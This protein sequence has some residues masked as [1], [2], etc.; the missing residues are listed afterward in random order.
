MSEEN[1]SSHQQGLVVVNTSADLQQMQPPK[2][3]YQLATSVTH[4]MRPSVETGRVHVV[5]SEEED[6]D[7]Y[8]D[9]DDEEDDGLVIDLNEDDEDNNDE[10]CTQTLKNNNNNNI[11]NDSEDRNECKRIKLCDLEAQSSSSSS[12]SS[13]GAREGV[14]SN[15]DNDA[16]N[17]NSSDGDDESMLDEVAD[18]DVDT[19]DENDYFVMLQSKVVPSND[20]AERR[21]DHDYQSDNLHNKILRLPSSSSS[22]ALLNPPICVQQLDS[23]HQFSYSKSGAEAAEAA[24]C[25]NLDSR[26]RRGNLPKDSV[27]VLK[28]WLY[29][30]RYNAYPTENEK[31]FL[32]KR[33]N[34]TVSAWT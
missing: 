9:D 23:S 4:L 22:S 20:S 30:H 32:S 6:N 5:I 14:G 15:D 18:A 10:N 34:L 17:D 31:T 8:D 29:E 11:D 3:T 13:Q 7:G 26:K 1:V 28:M 27:K 25:S 19:R 2:Q 12:S 33:A 21:R 16:D 24:M